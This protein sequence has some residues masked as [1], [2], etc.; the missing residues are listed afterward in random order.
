MGWYL[1]EV[2]FGGVGPWQGGPWQ[3]GT[4]VGWDLGRVGP[5]RGGTKYHSYTMC[6]ARAFF[7]EDYFSSLCQTF[8]PTSL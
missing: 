4:L 3:G 5:W 6:G 7:P 8:R 1:G 2:D